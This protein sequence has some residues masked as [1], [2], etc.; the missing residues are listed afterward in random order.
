[1]TAVSKNAVA[2]ARSLV[3]MIELYDADQKR[4]WVSE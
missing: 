2:A 1:M 3:V 4:F